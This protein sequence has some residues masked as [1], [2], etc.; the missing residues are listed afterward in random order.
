MQKTATTLLFLLVMAAT[1]A[2]REAI[3]SLNRLLTTV[4][5]DTT[6]ANTLIEFGRYYSFSKPDSAL[7]LVHQGLELARRLNYLKG[8]ANGL[9][10]EGIIFYKTGNL[11]KALN[12]FLSALK[13]NEKR[14]DRLAIAKNLGNIAN[15]YGEQGDSRRSIDFLLQT[16]AILEELHNERVLM[17]AMNN[18][19]TSY[20]QL[21]MLDSARIYVLQGY[22]L[23]LKYNDLDALGTASSILGTIYSNMNSPELALGYYRSSISYHEQVEDE[24][25]ICTSTLGMAELFTKSGQQDSALHYARRSVLTGLRGGFTNKVLEASKFLAVYFKEKRQIDSAFHYQELAITAKDSLFSE[26]KIKEVENLSLAESQRQQEIAE[27]KRLEEKA[28]KKNLQLAGIGIGLP[29]LF[30][31][32]MFLSRRR[33][34]PRSI[35]FLSILMLLLTFEFIVMLLRPAIV[36]LVRLANEAPAI[37]IFIHVG[38]GSALVPLQRWLERWVK[39]KLSHRQKT[40]P[41][42]EAV[43]N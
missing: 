21:N 7:L 1:H 8:E 41:V 42:A 29:A 9:N 32:L 30:L 25:G 22:E 33:V 24:E 23:A 6:R 27:Q 26:E 4:K 31:L 43:K 11:P 36:Y 28:H 20:Q 5:D 19:G 38:I 14:N 2:Q 12:Y 35:N 3:D 37:V 10:M 18:L 39:S 15:I 13:I 34:K 40:Q 16:K 17:I